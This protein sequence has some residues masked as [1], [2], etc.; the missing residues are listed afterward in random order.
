MFADAGD[1]DCSTLF[2]G[3]FEHQLRHDVGVVVVEMRYR[4][5]GY[6]K[7]EG[8]NQG[9]HHSH[10]LLLSKRHKANLAIHLVGYAKAFEPRKDGLLVGISRAVSSGKRRNSWKSML[11]W[12]RR[13]D[14][15]SLTR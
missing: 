12:L 14:I 4:L 10:T 3:F 6:D 15:Q 2:A 5:V 9:S 13:T 11:I 7:V 1:N 8:L